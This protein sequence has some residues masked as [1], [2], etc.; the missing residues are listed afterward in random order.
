[1]NL[2]F[3]QAL[4]RRHW[5]LAFILLATMLSACSRDEQE[6]FENVGESPEPQ[7]AAHSS[8]M[9]SIYVDRKIEFL[10]AGVNESLQG[11][12]QLLDA[13]LKANF[14]TTPLSSE[15]EA[16]LGTE[17]WQLWR[18]PDQFAYRREAWSLEVDDSTPQSCRFSLRAEGNHVYFDRE[19]TR[20]IDLAT[21]E[22]FDGPPE[23][24]RLQLFDATPDEREYEGLADWTGPS[25]QTV[26]GQKCAR[27]QS[28]S[29][30]SA[31]YWSEGT[32]WGFSPLP[33]GSFATNAGFPI[34]EIALEAEPIPGDAGPRLTTTQFVMGGT[35]DSAAM[36]PRPADR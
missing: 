27:W 20:E 14:T 16:R 15:D 1:L 7:A 11:Y 19:Q 9:P 13:C 33:T 2:L 30:D 8:S 32:Q 3:Q 24:D 17:R 18:A 4:P 35:L 29:G 10:A 21:G 23:P 6:Q 31:C 28:P 36:M 34:Y 12:R 22:R 25:G 5:T 26:K